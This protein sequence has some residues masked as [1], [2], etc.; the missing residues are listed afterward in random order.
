VYAMG[1]T[2]YY[3]LTG[4]VPLN[5]L[6]RL[7]EDEL[8]WDLP[9]L[10][11]LPAPALNTLRNALSVKAKDRTQSMS[12][13]LAGLE[14]AAPGPG[15]EPRPVSKLKPRPK[16]KAVSRKRLLGIVGIC[17]VLIISSAAVFMSQHRKAGPS[18]TWKMDRAGVLTI[19][20]SGKMFDYEVLEGP[21]WDGRKSDITAVIVEPGVT[22]IGDYAFDSCEYLTTVTLPEGLRVIGTNAFSFCSALTDVTL[23]KSLIEIGDRAFHGCEFT[24]ITLPEGLTRIGKYTFGYIINLTS[25]TIPKSVTTIDVDAFC[26]CNLTDVY[27][28]GTEAQ[29]EEIIIDSSNYPLRKAEIHYN[30]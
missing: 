6:D 11:S 5:A 20:G 8:R 23:P 18:I 29:W 12:E 30:S 22:H 21:P 1:A 16:R 9:S 17:A 19:S 4:I 25:I 13:L 2:I 27:Y 7:C 26:L 14:A 15:P 10:Q 3:T 24:S 28:T